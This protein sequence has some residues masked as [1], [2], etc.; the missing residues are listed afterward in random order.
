MLFPR[1]GCFFGVSA[2]L[3]AFWGILGAFFSPVSTEQVFFSVFPQGKFFLF[4]HLLALGEG[5]FFSYDSEQSFFF[6]RILWAKFFFFKN[7]LPPPLKSNGA[8]IYYVSERVFPG[9]THYIRSVT[10]C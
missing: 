7:F 2:I 3:G 9:I 4:H 1:F 5:V 10:A 6:Y 8:S